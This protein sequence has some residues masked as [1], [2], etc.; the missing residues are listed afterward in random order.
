MV[1]TTLDGRIL[2][3]EMV[4]KTPAILPIAAIIP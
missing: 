4:Q 2:N 3:A 1:K